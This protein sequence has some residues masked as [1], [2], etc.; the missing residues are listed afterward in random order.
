MNDVIEVPLL[1]YLN[2][3]SLMALYAS[4]VTLSWWTNLSA[5]PLAI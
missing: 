2:V 1:Y 3:S 4:L 5:T